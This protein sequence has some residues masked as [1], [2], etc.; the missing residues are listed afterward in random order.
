MKPILRILVVEDSEED[1]ELLKHEVRRSGYEISA[2]RVETAGAL[3][4]ALADAKWD[5]VVSDWSLPGF[6]GSAALEL[7]KRTDPDLPFFIVSGTIDEDLAVSALKSGAQDFV[8]KGRLA[9]LLPAFEREVREARERQQRRAA[10]AAVEEAQRQKLAAEA[11]S[12]AKSRFLA[13]MSHELRTP[14]NA[15]IGFSELLEDETAGAVNQRQK[16]YIRNVAQAGRHLLKLVNEILDLSRIEAGRVELSLQEVSLF[17]TSAEVCD[18]LAPQAASRQI[19]LTSAIPRDLPPVRADAVKLRQILFNLLSN[20]IKFTRP[21]GSVQLE[22]RADH[23]EMEIVVR[24][25]GIGIRAEDMPRLFQEFE[26]LDTTRTAEAEGT[27]LGLVLTKKL[28]EAQSGSIS[29]SSEPDKGSVFRVRMP[30]AGSA[31]AGC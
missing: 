16:G 6:S 22:A 2:R 27:G 28:V 20:G 15:I 5:L 14:L 7:C 17:A 23:G 4:A 8:V 19:A 29:V 18:T 26:R 25:T 11:A 1:F 12:Q 31:P 13:G 30:L 3:T 24:D 9:R 21:G 10:Q